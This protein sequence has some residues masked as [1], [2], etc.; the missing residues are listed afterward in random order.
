MRRWN[1]CSQD[2]GA[3]TEESQKKKKTIPGSEDGSYL[4]GNEPSWPRPLRYSKRQSRPRGTL[5]ALPRG[6]QGT[7]RG[8]ERRGDQQRPLVVAAFMAAS[9]KVSSMRGWKLGWKAATCLVSMMLYNKRQIRKS[10]ISLAEMGSYIQGEELQKLG[11]ELNQGVRGS[12]VELG[13]D[14]N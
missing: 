10:K 13:V 3:L 12:S 7:H 2:P 6:T 9:R 8:S 11:L 14:L 4:T 5:R 1:H